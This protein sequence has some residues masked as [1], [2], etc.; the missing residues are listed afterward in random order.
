MAIAIDELADAV[1]ELPRHW[2]VVALRGLAALIFGILAFAWP[3]VTLGVLILLFGSFAIVNGLLALFGA[4]RTG[5]KHM[6]ALVIEGVCGVLAGIATFVWP[7]L[8]AL[9]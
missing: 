5:G 8:T 9:A 3:G 7:G 2:W 4:L 1:R 6:W